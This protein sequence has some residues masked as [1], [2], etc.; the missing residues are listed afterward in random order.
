MKKKWP[1]LYSG[2][3]KN[4]KGTLLFD[5]EHAGILKDKIIDCQFSFELD[6]EGGINGQFKHHDYFN[7]TEQTVPVTGFISEGFLSLVA[8]FPSRV[9]YT[10]EGS[11]VLKSEKGDHEMAFYG[12]MDEE[13]EK[14]NGTWEIAEQ[15]FLD[16]TGVGTYYS[17]GTFEIVPET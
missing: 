11:P 15:N 14:I 6:N 5:P 13:S 7:L 4:W 3:K 16:V 9:F 10:E 12:D 17:E 1:I 2:M 8:H